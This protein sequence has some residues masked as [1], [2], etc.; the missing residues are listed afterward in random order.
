MFKE[1]APYVITAT[2]IICALIAIR[3]KKEDILTTDGIF[4][5]A[6]FALGLI[7]TSLNLIYSNNYLISLGPLLAIACLLYLRFRD[8]ILTSSTEFNLNFDNKTLKIINILY[9]LCIS[10]AI[11]SYY[12]APPYYRPPIFFITITL[13]ATLLGLEILA[14][15]YKD[16]INVF[17][18]I[19]KILFISLI[20]RASAY[21]ISPYPVGSDPW[22]H[23]RYINY[24]LQ[25]HHVMVPSDS[26]RYM[27]YYCSYPIVHLLACA[28][29]LIG[30]ISIKE[31]MFI[32]GAV[33]ALS[34]I[35]VYLIVKKITNNIN[36]ALLAM[37]LLNFADFH[38]EWSIEVIGMTFGIA[39]YAII[40]YLILK[41]KEKH[42]LI[43]ASLLI[44]FLFVIIWTHTVSS[45]I[46]LVS[47]ISLYVGS[48]VYPAIYVKHE[49]KEFVVSLTFCMIFAVILITHWMDPD[50]P[51]I[52]SI[53]R[54]LVNS[55]NKEAVFL[56]REALTFALSTA[57]QRWESILN[58]I[59][60]LIYVFFGIIGSLY[61]LSRK[62]ANKTKVSFIFM[63][64]VLYFV[65]FAFPLFG[66]R[67]ILPY[68]WPAF[69][70][71][72]FV[73]FVVV[74][75]IGFL[76]M[77]KSK[78]Q[79]VAFVFIVLVVTSF[80]MTTNF[81]TNMD[82]PIYGSEIVRRRIATESEMT[83]SRNV[84][85]FYNGTIMRYY[86]LTPAGDISWNYMKNNLFIW[87]RISFTRP[88]RVQILIDVG[89]RGWPDILL[90]EEF[91][92]HLDGNC[93]CMY[94]TGGARAYLSH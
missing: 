77:L 93:S 19:S 2:L 34:T 29:N 39:I 30:N 25:F 59:G 46:A 79:K 86:A 49:Y 78:K 54:G 75:L 32:I 44:I 41:T 11:I 74:G 64:I 73:L 6:G 84:D 53:T 81:V 17:S 58:I 72:S 67:N 15:K 38:I 62:N 13:G 92:D 27:V 63:L 56:G 60:F 5:V 80:F 31:S 66:I 91:K 88:V 16:N 57:E 7:I 12:Q 20:L 43:Y 36:L 28:S 83:L 69:I 48:F 82:S 42:Q 65:F 51:F 55:L 1:L 45:F 9:W 61:C 89:S 85:N 24:F 35:F 21:F 37:L 4:S 71:V 70:Y 33:L 90:G 47:V 8:R 94:D 40:I 87:K 50:Y 68:R 18:T 76:S 52:D 14:S 26:P 23:A 10:V 3:I 22:A